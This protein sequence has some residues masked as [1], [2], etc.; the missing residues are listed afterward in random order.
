MIF[1]STVETAGVPV[2]RLD[3]DIVLHLGGRAEDVMRRVESRETTS[4]RNQEGTQMSMVSRTSTT[5]CYSVTVHC[6]FSD[7]GDDVEFHS[8]P[9]K[10][11]F[12]QY[13]F[14]LS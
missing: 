14:V 3:S 7:G 13:L 5:A 10:T 2:Q 4:W 1:E 12:R 11:Y 9:V 8:A 6:R